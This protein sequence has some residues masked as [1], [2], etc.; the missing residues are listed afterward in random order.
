M[1]VESTFIICAINFESDL[2]VGIF[3]FLYI[4]RRLS[5]ESNGMLAY[6]LNPM[7]IEGVGGTAYGCHSCLICI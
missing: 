3:I 6:S 2:R 5:R 1:C 7:R 4:G